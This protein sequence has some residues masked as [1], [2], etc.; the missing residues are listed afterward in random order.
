MG[1]GDFFSGIKGKVTES[2]M[3]KAIENM[4]DL[5]VPVKE[6][7]VNDLIEQCLVG[8]NGVK[9]ASVDLSR[10]GVEVKISYS[11]GR[12]SEKRLLGFEKMIWTPQKKAFNFTCGE[13]PLSWG[14]YAC[15]CVT[16]GTLLRQI[17]GFNEKKSP[18][19]DEFSKDIQPIIEG[20]LQKEGRVN[21]DLRRVPFLRQYYYFK[22]MGQSPL[23]YMNVVDCWLE[24]GKFIVRIDNNAVVDK[25]KS[26]DPK[27]LQEAMKNFKESDLSEEE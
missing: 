22:V 6:G 1:I 16:L 7:A 8:K 24:G 27:Q 20:I 5:K 17:M 23:E 4:R 19:K 13:E 9:K 11:D 15:M 2:V 18:Y 12:D 26:M 21:F 10:D 3:E 14:V 25:L